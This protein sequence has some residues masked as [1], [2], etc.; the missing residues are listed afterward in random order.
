MWD[1]WWFVGLFTVS[2]GL[3]LAFF[4]P[5]GSGRWYAITCAAVVLI[6]LLAAVADLSALAVVAVGGLALLVT[7]GRSSG[8]RSWASRGRPRALR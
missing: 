7:A 6:Y 1:S 2:C 4:S 8:S 3:H 5:A